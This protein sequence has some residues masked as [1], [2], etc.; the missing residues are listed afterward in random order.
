MLFSVRYSHMCPTV[1]TGTCC[2]WRTTFDKRKLSSSSER[3]RGN[4]STVG[5][6]QLFHF[7]CITPSCQKHKEWTNELLGLSTSVGEWSVSSTA[8]YIS[9]LVHLCLTG[10][11]PPPAMK[12]QCA[13][14]I[15][16]DSL[17][18]GTTLPKTSDIYFKSKYV[19][20]W[21]QLREKK[22]NT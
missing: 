1:S 10:G 21:Q 13:G 19:A 6:C 4:L 22:N 17:T 18:G 12:R 2:A 3:G 8:D 15:R 7:G 5:F 14:T 11:A 20:D 9:L 16:S